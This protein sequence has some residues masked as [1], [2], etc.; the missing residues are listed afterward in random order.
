[1]ETEAEPAPEPEAD[2][3]R[4]HAAA[5]EQAGADEGMV[6]CSVCGFPMEPEWRVCPNCVTRYETKCGTCGRT[7][8]PW[9]LIC[10]WCETRRPLE[11]GGR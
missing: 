8:Q 4:T 7:L 5:P 10:P 2:R 1:M 11:H 9:W 3:Y 6:A